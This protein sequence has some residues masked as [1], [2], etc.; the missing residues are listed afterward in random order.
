MTV[1]RISRQ[2]V[3]GQVYRVV[4]VARRPR[5]RATDRRLE[6]ARS[7]VLGH[8][9]Q[10]WGCL[11]AF[12][13]TSQGL[14][15]AVIYGGSPFQEMTGSVGPSDARF[16]SIFPAGVPCV[17]GYPF[18]CINITGTPLD[19][20]FLLGGPSAYCSGKYPFLSDRVLVMFESSRT[21]DSKIHMV[22][23]SIPRGSD[24]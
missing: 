19:W 10:P 17:P 18:T 15:F 7:R 9:R 16:G 12:H 3:R 1:C 22:A 11:E 20:I 13:H 2:T 21:C 23:S 14:L 5:S 24:L 4:G 6:F 8:I